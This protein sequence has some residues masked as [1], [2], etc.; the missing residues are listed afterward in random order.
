MKY[1]PVAQYINSK[2][3]LPNVNGAKQIVTQSK[4]LTMALFMLYMKAATGNK[5]IHNIS[6]ER[7]GVG[8]RPMNEMNLDIPLPVRAK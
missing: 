3:N 5:F 2:N 8:Q 7:R 4:P 1:I 6:L